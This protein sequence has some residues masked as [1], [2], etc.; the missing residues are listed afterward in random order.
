MGYW[1]YLFIIF[2]IRAK[3]G[4]HLNIAK[5]MNI[6]EYLNITGCNFKS[7]EL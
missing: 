4:F 5:Y 6:K 3:L 1:Q 7:V 2:A